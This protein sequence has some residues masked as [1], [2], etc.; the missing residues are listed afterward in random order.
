MPYEQPAPRVPF[1]TGGDATG[2]SPPSQA[3]SASE[4]AGARFSGRVV[5][6]R[7]EEPV[8]ELTVTLTRGGRSGNAMTRPDGSFQVAA[9]LPTGK[10]VVEIA[11]LDTLVGGREQDFASSQTSDLGTIRVRIGPTVPLLVEP[12]N[13][14]ACTARLVESARPSGIAGVIDVRNENLEARTPLEGVGDRDW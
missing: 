9:S 14:K 6:D 10:L 5:D 13:A 4:S 8:P 11:D 12:E 1:R 3:P 7:T 2:G